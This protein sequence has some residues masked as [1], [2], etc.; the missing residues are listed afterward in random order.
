MYIDY[1]ISKRML[2]IAYKNGKV[3]RYFDVEPEVWDDYRD[4][5]KSGGS[6]GVYVNFN[7]KPHFECKEVE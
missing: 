6:S 1:M 7:V 5:V 3:Y 4:L 2:E